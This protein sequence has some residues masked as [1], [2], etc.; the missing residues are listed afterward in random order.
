MHACSGE[1]L[2]LAR[3]TSAHCQRTQRDNGRNTAGFLFSLLVTL[4][5]ASSIQVCLHFPFDYAI[6]MREY[7][8]GANT[9]GPYFLGRTMA[10]IPQSLLFLLLG[11]IPYFM[12]GLSHAPVAFW[13]FVLI[14]FV[15]NFAAQSLG[16]LASSFT[17]NPIVGLSI[18][19]CMTEWVWVGA[20]LC[21][22][23]QCA[24]T[25]HTNNLA[26]IT[27]PKPPTRQCR[28]SS[29]P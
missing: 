11:I 17:S 8:S 26:L 28:S 14:L 24:S 20:W 13:Y 7:Y 2:T 4:L 18:C 19:E 15:L 9:P 6:L 3:P 29:R 10:S 16:Y 12:T 21:M 5:I 25:A 27:P 22:H 1:D 23:A